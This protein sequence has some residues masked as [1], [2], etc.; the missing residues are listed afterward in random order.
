[1]RP[2]AAGRSRHIR[3]QEGSIWPKSVPVDSLVRGCCYV[4]AMEGSIRAGNPQRPDFAVAGV[5]PSGESR[6]ADGG[7]EGMAA[8]EG[9]GEG[10]TGSALARG[11]QRRCT[12]PGCLV[13]SGPAQTWSPMDE[14]STS[15]PQLEHFMVGSRPMSMVAAMLTIEWVRSGSSNSLGQLRQLHSHPIGGEEEEV[16]VV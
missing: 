3:L 14:I 13:P 12:T 5:N 7:G 16:S 6:P 9:T 8:I 4:L 15:H 2:D 11:R 1:M 10:A